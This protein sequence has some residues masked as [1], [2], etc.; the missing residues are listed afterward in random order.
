MKKPGGGAG[1]EATTPVGTKMRNERGQMLPMSLAALL[2]LAL[3]AG[4]V[5]NLGKLC[6]DRQRLGTSR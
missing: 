1:R 5:L 6:L 4:T 3:L 2:T